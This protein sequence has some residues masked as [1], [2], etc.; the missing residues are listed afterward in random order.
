MAL[1]KGA[2]A[3]MG[4]LVLGRL[5]ELADEFGDVGYGFVVG[6]AG[7]AGRSESGSEVG[8]LGRIIEI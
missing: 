7:L 1:G 6:E 8:P 5:H 4:R 2:L 3:L